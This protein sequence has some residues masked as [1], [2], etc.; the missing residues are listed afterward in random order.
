MSKNLILYAYRGDENELSIKNLEFFV[1]NGI[2]EDENIVYLIIVNGN[3]K[4][5]VRINENK[6]LKVLLYKNYGHGWG[7][8]EYGLKNVNINEYKYF[9]FIKDTARGPFLDLHKNWVSI[10]TNKIN[11]KVKLVGP[12]INLKCNTYNYNDNKILKFEPHVQS[13]FFVTDRY[14]LDLMNLHNIFN[15]NFSSKISNKRE[16]VLSVK[17]FE[18]DKE[19]ESLID[20]FEGINMSKLYKLKVK[21]NSN[22]RYILNTLLDNEMNY[23]SKDYYKHQYFSNPNPYEVIFCK[24][25]CPKKIIDKLN[26]L[27]GKLS[28]KKKKI[29]KLTKKK[30]K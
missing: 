2:I 9:F 16:V 1:N 3:N 23:L 29:R 24:T 22:K 26:K 13:F 17:M 6:N 15:K 28:N 25:V 20:N 7:S 12:S 11:D 14:G 21:Y 18:Q 27:G 5:S 19:I 30:R 10:F 8:W 4:P